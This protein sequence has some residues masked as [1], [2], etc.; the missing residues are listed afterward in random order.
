MI[1][2]FLLTLKQQRL[3]AA[4]LLRPERNFTF[5]ALQDIVPG[6][7]GSLYR[8]VRTLVDAGVL[9]STQI[10]GSK[11]YQSNKAHPLYPEL[12]SI[13]VKTF[14]VA[15]PIRDALQPFAEHIERA[16]IFGSIV[17]G[18]DNFESDIDIMVVGRV[19]KGKLLLALQNTEKLT[20]RPVHLNVYGCDEWPAATQ[21]PVIATILDGPTIELHLGG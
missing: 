18:S 2:D 21:D 6:G 19:S 16:F 12:R 13:A 14:G 5:A 1:S 9:T 20:G 17:K 11:L 3:L 4:V 7:T 10:R 15:E 8:Y